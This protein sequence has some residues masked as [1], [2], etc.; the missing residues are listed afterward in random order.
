[1]TL[2][3]ISLM[4][5]FSDLKWQSFIVF[6]GREKG[7]KIHSKP[8]LYY[9]DTLVNPDTYLSRYIY[10]LTPES[11]VRV[12]IIWVVVKKVDVSFSSPPTLGGL[13]TSVALGRN[14]SCHFF[15]LRSVFFQPDSTLL[16]IIREEIRHSLDMKK[17]S[18]NSSLCLKPF[19]FSLVV[20]PTIGLCK[21]DF[22]IYLSTLAIARTKVIGLLNF[23]R[24]R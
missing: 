10:Q 17:A 13:L 16:L 18:R 23:S 7:Q 1:M 5:Q 20:L 11:G 19:F 12:V 4:W 9:P 3:P 6:F 15:C 14:F 24:P 22:S 8:P 2:F 21:R